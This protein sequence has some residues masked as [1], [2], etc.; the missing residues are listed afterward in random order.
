MNYGI[1]KA[2]ILVDM[3]NGFVNE[4]AMADKE[5]GHIIPKQYEYMK[6]VEESLDSLNIIIKDRHKTGCREFTHYPVHC[7]EGTS[8]SELV[9]E[10]KEFENDNEYVF[11]KNSTSA[12]F[13][14]GFIEAIDSMNEL[15]EIVIA[16]CCTDIC[17]MNLAIP[18]Q[19]YFDQINRDVKIIIYK[20]MV[21][22][23]D[24]PNHNRDEYNEMAFKLI[25]QAGIEIK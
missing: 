8:E 19:N 17:I 23:Y 9:P 2:Y 6:K 20:D 24:A 14:P 13:A 16:G 1:K 12:I 11:P 7:V 21:E 5:I 15:E 4:G 22:T 18:L 25:G 10:L 3:V